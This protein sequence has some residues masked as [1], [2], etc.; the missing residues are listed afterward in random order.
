MKMKFECYDCGD[1]YYQELSEENS[2]GHPICDECFNY[3]Y[4]QCGDCGEIIPISE[5]HCPNNCN[6]GE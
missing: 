5:E 1:I 2:D 3:N 6:E 4:W